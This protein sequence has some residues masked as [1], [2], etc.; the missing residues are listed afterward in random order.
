MGCSAL[1]VLRGVIQVQ[2]QRWVAGQGS[3][4]AGACDDRG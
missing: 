4:S 2:L 3:G 1:D